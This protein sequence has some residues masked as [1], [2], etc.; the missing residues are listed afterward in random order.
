MV[1]DSPASGLNPA[2]RS[3]PAGRSDG[4]NST[5]AS[6]D[7]L[8]TG[9]DLERLGDYRILRELGR[10]GMGVV[11]EAERESLKVRV[12]LKVMHPT[13][14]T[15][16]SRLRRFHVEARSA[17]RLH[18]T[19]IVPVFDFGDQDGICYYAMQMI[20]GVGLNQVIDEVRRLRSSVVAAPVSREAETRSHDPAA[21]AEPVS[22]SLSLASEG[23]VTGRFAIGPGRGSGTDPTATMPIDQTEA[24][25]TAH[26]GARPGSGSRT[27]RDPDPGGS[28]QS[29]GSLP[30]RSDSAYHREVAR[31]CARWPMRS[32]TRIDRA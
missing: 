9:A 6:G 30:G 24:G 12:A 13:F 16:A 5:E 14:R 17:A 21:P 19:N 32:T 29:G 31:I 18:H 3:V 4:R 27:G 11:Y 8:R 7:P 22:V 28:S 10:G 25:E 20:S 26:G 2:D 23:L 1:T 15:D